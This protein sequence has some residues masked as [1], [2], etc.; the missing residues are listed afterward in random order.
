MDKTF[1]PQSK[2]CRTL[3]SRSRFSSRSSEGWI[4]FDDCLFIYQFDYTDVVSIFRTMFRVG[5]VRL[6]NFTLLNMTYV[7][8]WLQ[9]CL[10]L[11]CY[12]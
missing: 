7:I 8:L 5:I 11:S 12:E 6:A 4:Y 2:A 9:V 10:C 3:S 1:S